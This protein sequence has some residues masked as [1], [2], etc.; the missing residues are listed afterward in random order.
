MIPTSWALL[1]SVYPG[2]V[3]IVVVMSTLNLA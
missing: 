1:L 2:Q 3:I